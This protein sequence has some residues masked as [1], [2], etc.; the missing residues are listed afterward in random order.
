MFARKH[1]CYQAS[2]VRYL[3]S[4]LSKLMKEAGLSITTCN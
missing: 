3:K 1:H 4:K 2:R